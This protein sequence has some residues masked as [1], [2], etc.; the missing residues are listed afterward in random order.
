MNFGDEAGHPLQIERPA[1]SCA[2][3]VE[4]D[5]EE[6]AVRAEA[7]FEADLCLGEGPFPLY[8]GGE[9]SVSKIKKVDSKKRKLSPSMIST[10]TFKRI[11]ATSSVEGGEDEV[12]RV[13][14]KTKRRKVAEKKVAMVSTE[15]KTENSK[16]VG[17]E[18]TKE[19]GPETNEEMESQMKEKGISGHDFYGLW[20]CGAEGGTGARDLKSTMTSYFFIRNT[21]LSDLKE[22][23]ELDTES[24]PTEKANTVLVV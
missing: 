20:P 19:L 13:E 5:D 24:V 17:T 7:S 22:K 15:V 14:A 1:K 16:K 10:G 6:N 8:E 2:Q 9:P 4:L 3:V 11:S 18:K 12:R 23:Y 21:L